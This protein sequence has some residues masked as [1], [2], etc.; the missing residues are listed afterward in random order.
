L[1]PASW[2]WPAPANAI[3]RA[4]AIVDR[5]IAFGLVILVIVGAALMPAPL[6]ARETQGREV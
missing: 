4:V 2:C 3:D 5:V 6:R 1:A